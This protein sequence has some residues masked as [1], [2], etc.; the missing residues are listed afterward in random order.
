MTKENLNK[1]SKGILE[2]LEDDNN[3][4]AKEDKSKSVNNPKSK[5]SFMLTDKQ[6]RMLYEL[7]LELIHEDLSTIVGKAIESYYNSFSQ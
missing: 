2:G 4:K 3:L 7:K 5:R 6:I 1:I